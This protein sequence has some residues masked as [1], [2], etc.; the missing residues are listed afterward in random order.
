MLIDGYLFARHPHIFCLFVELIQELLNLSQRIYLLLF[1][2]AV[3]VVGYCKVATKVLPATSRLNCLARC[4]VL[5]CEGV[6]D[7]VITKQ[8]F[9]VLRAKPVLKL[10]LGG[11]AI[12]KEYTK[13]LV[14]L[15]TV[16]KK[17][18]YSSLPALFA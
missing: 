4:T 10:W 7:E 17:S 3:A 16:K 1:V 8:Q 14:Q 6:A 2:W 9:L 15:G 12:C 5:L 13:H 11:E 18:V